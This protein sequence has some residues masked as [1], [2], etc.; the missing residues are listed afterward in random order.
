RIVDVFPSDRQGQIR[1]QLSSTLCGVIAQRLVAR[2]GGGLLA[3][4]EGLLGTPP[5]QN[6]FREGK[7]NP[8][9]HALPIALTPGHK[10]LEMSLN[11]LVGAGIITPEAAVATAFVP[12]EIQGAGIVSP[13]AAQA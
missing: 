8:L 6:P 11:E 2:I 1:Q 12:H 4:H 5:R 9:P 3:P 10:T 7:V 13:L